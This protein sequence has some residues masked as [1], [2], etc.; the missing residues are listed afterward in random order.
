MLTQCRFVAQGITSQASQLASSAIRGLQVPKNPARQF[1]RDTTFLIK[2]MSLGY[3]IYVQGSYASD[4]T[5]L[6]R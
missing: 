4:N 2:Y 1:H 3:N 5:R 6:S